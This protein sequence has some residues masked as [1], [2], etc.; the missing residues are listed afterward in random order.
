M[1]DFLSKAKRSALMSKI[2]GDN[3]KPETLL[4][5]ALKEQSVWFERNVKELP[6]KPDF[7]VRL[8]PYHQVSLVV[9]VHGCFWHCCPRHFKAPKTRV[10]HWEAHFAKNV[11]RDKRVRRALRKIGY[12]TA[13]VWEHEVNTAA[14]AAAAAARIA[15]RLKGTK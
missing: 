5:T 13:V 12:R 14:K 8:D 4:A 11:A 2:T 3:L 6:G 9:F 15:R 7:L 1:T 10:E